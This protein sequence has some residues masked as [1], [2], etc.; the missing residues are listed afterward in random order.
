MGERTKFLVNPGF[1]PSFLQRL[2]Q[3]RN[4]GGVPSLLSQ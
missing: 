4:W 1:S 3:G 2:G